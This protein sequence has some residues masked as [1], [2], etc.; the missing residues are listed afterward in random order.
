MWTVS[1]EYDLYGGGSPAGLATR[2][3]SVATAVQSL[4]AGETAVNASTRLPVSTPVSF[5]EAFG[6]PS[7]I[8][9][10]TTVINAIESA[11]PGFVA[12]RYVAAVNTFNPGSDLTTWLGQF[13]TLVPNTM[14]W[15]SE[16]GTAVANSCNGYPTPPCTPSEQQQATFLTAQL[17]ATKPGAEGVSLGA[18]VFEFEDETWKGGTEAT[19]GMFKFADPDNYT[20]VPTSGGTYRVDQLVAKASAAAVGSAFRSG[21]GALPGAGGVSVGDGQTAGHDPA[22]HPGTGSCDPLLAACGA[23]AQEPEAPA[24]APSPSESDEAPAAGPPA[25]PNLRARA[26]ADWQDGVVRVRVRVLISRPKL[27]ASPFRVRVRIPAL[28]VTRE[29]PLSAN[30]K[31]VRTLLLAFDGPASLVG[32]RVAVTVDPAGRILE[33]RERDNT[34]RAL[35][36]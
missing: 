2:A 5:S 10:T 20:T 1:N 12:S 3:A 26:G 19:F 17:A 21:S 6:T 31:R 32:K 18:A 25:M 27:V 22:A 29:L 13:K 34:V 30:G 16:L 8:P 9:A 23:F 33:T 28:G 14:V 35:I 4:V 15:F 24:F 36:T 11:V 7:A